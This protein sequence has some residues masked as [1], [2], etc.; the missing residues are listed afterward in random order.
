MARVI[1]KDE[2]TTDNGNMVDV[3]LQGGKKLL[4]V[5]LIYLREYLVNDIQRT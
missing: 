3:L 1:E 4:H 2:V 5:M